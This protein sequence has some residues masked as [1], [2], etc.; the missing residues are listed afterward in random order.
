MIGNGAVL[1]L[2]RI[3]TVL[4]EAAEKRTGDGVEDIESEKKLITGWQ[5]ELADMLCVG[6]EYVWGVQS[7]QWC[8]AR[9]T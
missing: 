2:D 7:P 9:F 5:G 3:A 1:E 6:F 4:K 8:F